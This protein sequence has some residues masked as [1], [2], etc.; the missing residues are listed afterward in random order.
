MYGFALGRCLLAMLCSTIY[1][2]LPSRIII[3]D[4][5]VNLHLVRRALSSAGQ[6]QG[7]SCDRAS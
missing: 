3:L 7:A 6:E 5:Q 1:G 4:L 2:F